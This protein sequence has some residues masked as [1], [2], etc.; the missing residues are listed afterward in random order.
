MH[1]VLIVL[2]VMA[3]CLATALDH[4]QDVFSMCFMSRPH[5]CVVRCWC[6]T[7]MLTLLAVPQRPTPTTPMVH[8]WALQVSQVVLV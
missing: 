3:M 6:V 8:Q 2:L 1:M 7:G 4:H 5:W